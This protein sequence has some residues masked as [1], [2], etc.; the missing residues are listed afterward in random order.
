VSVPAYGDNVHSEQEV[1]IVGT[2]WRNWDAW[3]GR[4]PSFE[5][6]PMGKKAEGD[7]TE[8]LATVKAANNEAWAKES[9]EIDQMI[10]DKKKAA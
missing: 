9:A 5:E 7:K 4:A 6:V 2:A 1:V 3:S 8:A 10:A